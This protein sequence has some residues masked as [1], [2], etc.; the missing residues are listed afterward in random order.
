MKKRGFTLIELLV[1]IAIIGILAAILLPA[2]ARARES[3]RR[4]SCQNNLKQWGL[5][6][7]M[8]GNESKGQKFPPLQFGMY[9]THPGDAGMTL[10]MD[11]GPEVFAIY[12]EYLTDPAI[13]YCPSD[14][15]AGT[16]QDAAHENGQWCWESMRRVGAASGFND[17]RDD[18][19]S[20]VD[21]SYNYTSFTFDKVKDTDDPVPY[22]D[23]VAVVQTLYSGAPTPPAGSVVPRQMHGALMGLITSVAA[24]ALSGNPNMNNKVD[25]DV[26]VASADAGSGNGGGNTVY[27]LR[28]GVERFM[29]TD[30]NNPA[31]SAMAQSELFVMWDHV[32]TS[33]SGFNHIPGGGNVL[34]MDGHVGFIKY[35]GEPPVS[36]NVA[37][38]L[39]LFI[40]AP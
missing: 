40:S 5:V 18:C 29:I 33:P 28:E 16:A 4:A 14:P 1:V 7:K 6:F 23:L 32:S 39:G 9:H 37:P 10:Y 21:K 31:A 20:G 19:A 13:A 15:D 2:L 34:Y 11:L 25:A 26:A 3:A 24:D 8:Y 27:R 35:P 22:T 30:I 38:A 36:R 12:P 17:S